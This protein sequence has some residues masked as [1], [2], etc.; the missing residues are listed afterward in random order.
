MV[1]N[2]LN[3]NTVETHLVHGQKSSWFHHNLSLKVLR[4]EQEEG[5]N[6]RPEKS[7][8]WKK[9]ERPMRTYMSDLVTLPYMPTAT[10]TTSI[11]YLCNRN[12][13]N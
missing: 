8:H 7:K 12:C 6:N 13:L 1:E 4:L 11:S 3:T 9:L 10:V 5:G 2:A